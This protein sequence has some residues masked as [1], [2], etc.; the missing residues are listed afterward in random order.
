[1]PRLKTEP[2]TT[3]TEFSEFYCDP[4]VARDYDRLHN[5]TLKKEVVR[6]SEQD[7]FTNIAGIPVV[8]KKILEIGSGTGE[9]TVRLVQ[10]NQVTAIDISESMLSLAREKVASDAA[11]FRVL[12]M[13]AL[14]E[15]NEDFDI[16]VAS[17]VFLHLKSDELARILELCGRRIHTG[18]F[19]LF[20][21]QRPSLWRLVLALF[22]KKKVTNPNFRLSEVEAIVERSTLWQF[23]SYI[24]FDHWPLLFP[25][26]FITG[27]ARHPNLFAL[28]RFVERKL[29]FFRFG[30]SRWGIVCRRR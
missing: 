26:A 4:S 19:L 22:E 23:D 13:F 16:I 18:G 12:D 25:A 27:G 7:F 24:C 8:G 21:L 2:Q 6:R 11:T 3:G 14:N 5:N 28:L 30:A 29:H 9:L 17:R 15:L 1:M 10:A 20:D